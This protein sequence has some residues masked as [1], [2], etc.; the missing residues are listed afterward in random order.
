MR[1]DDQVEALLKTRMIPHRND[2]EI[3]DDLVP[4]DRLLGVSRSTLYK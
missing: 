1:D 4:I 2:V 3:K